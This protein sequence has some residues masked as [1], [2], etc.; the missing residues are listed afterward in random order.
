MRDLLARV[1]LGGLRHVLWAWWKVLMQKALLLRRRQVAQKLCDPSRRDQLKS[2]QAK[3]FSR[4]QRA[5]AS[6]V[7]F[8]P[9]VQ[10]LELDLF[11]SLNLEPDYPD[12]PDLFRLKWWVLHF[13][14]LMSFSSSI[15]SLQSHATRLRLEQRAAA[16]FVAVARYDE[17][18]S[19]HQMHVFQAWRYV[20]TLCLA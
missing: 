5:S 18:S 17:L 20:D 8:A 6:H 16:H 3:V 14:H 2:F 19:K 12:H 11:K 15:E 7:P 13:W 9:C 1:V 10:D 4:S